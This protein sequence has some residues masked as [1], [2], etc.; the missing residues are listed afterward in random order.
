MNLPWNR[1]RVKRPG[2]FVIE[3]TTQAGEEGED[4]IKDGK[5]KRARFRKILARVLFFASL[6]GEWWFFRFK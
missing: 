4:K 3:Y 6:A 1:L 2:P 5:K